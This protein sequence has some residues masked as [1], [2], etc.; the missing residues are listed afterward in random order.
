[1]IFRIPP[2]AQKE[3]LSL[4]RICVQINLKQVRL[5]QPYRHLGLEVDEDRRKEC[6]KQTKGKKV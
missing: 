5:G 1:M 4:S 2:E 3:Q 6:Q